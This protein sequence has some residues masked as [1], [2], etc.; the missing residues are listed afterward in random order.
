M[1]LYLSPFLIYA[2]YP[3]LRTFH[4][5]TKKR[6]DDQ[7]LQAV[8]EGALQKELSAFVLNEL[9]EDFGLDFQATLTEELD[10]EYQQ[11]S[12]I[13]FFIQLKASQDFGG[14]DTAGF[15]ASTNDLNLYLQNPS[16]VILTLY[17][18]SEDEFYWTIV[19]EYIWD[20]L[21]ERTPDWQSQGSNTVRVDKDQTFSD[22]DH[23]R[24][25]VLEA[26]DRIV[27]RH[28]MA[29]GIGQGLQFSPDDPSELDMQIE[30]SLQDFKGHS[31]VKSA[32]M[33]KKGEREGAKGQLRKVYETP[34]E[35]E[36][37]LKALSGLLH[38]LHPDQGQE[39]ALR[40]LE[41]AEEG[42]ELAEDL[43]QLG[44]KKYIQIHKNHA[45]LSI[46]L[47][48]TKEILFSMKIQ[49]DDGDE[50][51]QVFLTEGLFDLLEEKLRVFGEINDALNILLKN[52]EYY[53][54]AISLPLIVDYITSQTIVYARLKIIDR[55][56]LRS[57]D[58][59]HPIVTQLTL[60]YLMRT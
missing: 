42:T 19:Q 49:E 5:V 55:D 46:L 4:A 21:E 14:G 2:F 6:S 36:G 33:L 56:E 15:S 11:V 43:D 17:D 41:L 24:T 25:R 47:D 9:S 12:S 7:E 20:E 31:L 23:L 59:V 26:Q 60:I 51:F 22:I 30:S 1:V 40:I 18:N 34:E 10:D 38:I 32:E 44:H 27:R 50:F 52:D 3:S 57:S 37:K 45:Q 28:N 35:D 16:P 8:S 58:Q 53:H 39:E 13:N 48:K 54:Y 29:M